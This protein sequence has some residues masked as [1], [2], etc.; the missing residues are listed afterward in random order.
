[1][2]LHHYIRELMT[3]HHYIREGVNMTLHHYIRELIW[4]STIILGS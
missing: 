4:H 2:T 1:M 3:L